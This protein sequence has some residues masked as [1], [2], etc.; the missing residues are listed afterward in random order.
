MYGGSV[1][2]IH[3]HEESLS[4]LDTLVAD[5]GT[6]L[7]AQGLRMGA[8]ESCTGGLVAHTL[9]NVAGS[10]AWFEG[11]VV[12]YDNR[13]KQA[14]LGVS[15][16]ILHSYG[17]V[18]AQCVEAMAV[19]V[20]RLLDVPVTVAVSGIAGPGGGSAD[21]PVGTVWMAWHING[22]VWS[23]VC[24]FCGDRSQIKAGSV[25]AVLEELGGVLIKK[26]RVIG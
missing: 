14:L 3:A 24:T 13:V 8:A 2:K 12:A 9:T 18:S 11:A 21:K 15:E 19:G 7:V 5:L 26:R 23:K 17:A 22:Q 20:A 16:Q 4:G 1:S 25:R 6:A 10:S